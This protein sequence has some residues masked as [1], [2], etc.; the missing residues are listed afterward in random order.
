[1]PLLLQEEKDVISSLERFSKERL[2]AATYLLK[3]GSHEHPDLLVYF[4]YPGYHGAFLCLEYRVS[5]LSD[6]PH[7]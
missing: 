5:A 1:M 6:G 7:W 2:E 4:A 3:W